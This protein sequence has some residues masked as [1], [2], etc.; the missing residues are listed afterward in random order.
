MTTATTSTGDRR[1]F[2]IED[3]SSAVDLYSKRLEQAGFKTASAF[4][5]VEATQALPE[6]SADLIILDLL[7]A[8]RGGVDL[9]KTIRADSRHKS[10]PVLVLSNAYLPELSQRALRAGGN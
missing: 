3:D 10:T 6:L 8:N 4:D 7:L 1:V 2:L 5:T 9:V